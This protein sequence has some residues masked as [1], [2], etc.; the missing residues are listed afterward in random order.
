MPSSETLRDPSILAHVE[1][2][3]SVS[4]KTFNAELLS[5]AETKEFSGA[6][7]VSLP[8]VLQ[9]RRDLDD[10]HS[11]SGSKTVAKFE[12]ACCWCLLATS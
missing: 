6:E 1:L 7:V 11:I 3:K 10:P 4:I 2:R 5:Q 9:V 12:I 8:Q